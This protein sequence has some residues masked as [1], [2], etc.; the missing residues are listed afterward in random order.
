MSKSLGNGVDPLEII[1]N[2]GADAL[3]YALVMGNS[4]GNDM[5]YSDKKVEAARNFANK[6]WNA[7]RFTLMNLTIDKVELPDTAKLKAEDKWIL[8][9]LNTLIGEV[10][11]NLDKFELGVAL[12]KLYDFVWD[13][14][15]DWYIELIKPRLNEGDTDAQN[16]LTYALGETLKLLHPF[17]PFITEEIYQAI[18]HEDESIMIAEYPKYNTALEFPTE[19]AQMAKLI[20]AITLIRNRRAEMNVAPSKKAKVIIAT[21]DRASYSDDTVKFFEKLA[22]ASEVEFV[23]TYA[24]ENAVQ[25]V[26]EGAS[27]FIPLGELIDFAKERE[28]LNKEREK[29]LSE[30]D[31]VEKK[32]ANEGFVAKAPAQLIEAEKAK[33]EKFIEQLAAVDE[34]IAKLG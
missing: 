26:A 20:D 31:R 25:I 2:Y 13:V 30:I 29:Y 7:S 12:S 8:S 18:P 15:C 28:R 10:N 21:A 14:L 24:D 16:V 3:R 22:S 11:T 5:R 19:E 4:P 27:I 17:M 1:D 33:K 6:L 34:A 23:E 32:L 9:K